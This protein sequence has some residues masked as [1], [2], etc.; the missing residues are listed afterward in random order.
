MD[1]LAVIDIGSNSMCLLVAAQLQDGSLAVV[2]KHKHAAR[3]RDEV[4]DAG[5]LSATGVLRAATVLAQFHQVLVNWRVERVRVVATAALRAA[6]NAD[7]LV[8]LVATQTGLSIEIISGET[9]AW[10][11]WR[12]VLG[13]MRRAGAAA[14]MERT[15]DQSVLCADVGGGS[16]ELLLS[17]GDEVLHTVSVPLGAL[18]VTKAWLGPDPVG[19]AAIAAAR[20][21]VREALAGATAPLRAAGVQ[22][23]VAASGTMQRV[24]RIACAQQGQITQDIHGMQLGRGQLAAVLAA[25]EA[26]PTHLQR[27]SIAG[28][29]PLRADSLL[30]GALIYEALTELLD[31]EAWSVSLDGLRMGVLT[32]LAAAGPRA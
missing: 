26:A 32:E 2:A 10:L 18:V 14:A 31:L 17:R 11:A 13:G 19:G 3:L 5:Q 28:M 25:L 8:R 1:T 23:A 22:A 12:G 24:A 16:T 20:Q 30:G 9:E 6:R 29:D 15:A 21:G 7:E 4:D 27:L